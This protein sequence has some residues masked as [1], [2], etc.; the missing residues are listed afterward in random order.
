MHLGPDGRLYTA[1]MAN[2]VPACGGTPGPSHDLSKLASCP[3][4]TIAVALDPRTLAHRVV[5]QTPVLAGFSN[6]TM[7]LPLGNSFFVGSFS[8]D[9]VATGTL[10]RP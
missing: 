5:L 2:D 6:A 8:A 4:G 9:R 1:G 10:P 7:L 3:R